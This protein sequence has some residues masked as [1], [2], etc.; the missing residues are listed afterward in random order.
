[1]RR[2]VLPLVVSLASSLWLGSSPAL[3]ENRIALVIGN[4]AYQS[5]TALPNPANDAKAMAELLTAAGFEVIAA[6]DLT[7]NDM[8]QTVRDFAEKVAAKG[9]DTI[10]L[11]FYAGHGLQVDG[12]NFLV[13]VDAHVEREADVPI[14]AF[15][16]GDL[17][18]ALAA[19][20]SKARIVMLD[21]CRNNP[22]A[23]IRKTTGRGLAIVDA[24]A[25]S[26]ISYSTSPG[27]EAEDGAGADSPYTTALLAV[28]RQPGL[29]IEQAFKR[30]RVAVNRATDGRQIPWESSSLGS[31]FF[32]FPGPGNVVASQPVSQTTATNTPPPGGSGGLGPT[33]YARPPAKSLEAW[34][35]ELLSV[36]PREA[37][38]IVIREDTIEGY[39]A[40]LAVYPL[41]PFAPRVRS[42]FD[43]RRE[44]IAWYF[45]VTINTVE[46]YRAFLAM[47]PN[48]D[49]TTTARRLVERARPRSMT[50][51]LN[52]LHLPSAA[53]ASAPVG[54][55][56]APSPVAAATPV[57]VA[58][59]CPCRDPL[60]PQRTFT[61][62]DP[63]F[64]P[65]PERIRVPPDVRLPPNDGGFIRPPPFVRPLPRPNDGVI[66]VPPSHGPTLPPK[67][68][69]P[70]ASL[71]PRGT[72]QPPPN[73]NTLPPKVTVIPPRVI[74][75]P[76]PV[77]FHPPPQNNGPG[78]GSVVFRPVPFRGGFNNAPSGGPVIR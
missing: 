33:G 62:P 18:N 26:I 19:V 35:R 45:A 56:P 9:Q 11:V 73:V 14:Q 61:P 2:P 41:P 42:L 13:P 24:P 36:A 21:A 40:Y 3:A 65:P 7:Q 27:A 12:E 43:R 58:P 66:V 22:F 53:Q 50:A 69:G 68:S 51:S 77:V 30:V 55:P 52:P 67:D 59:T 78:K 38:E 64:P 46:S 31:D 16:L 47:Y 1:M 17:M 39:E 15:R 28:A 6:P 63:T 57:N 49:L 70:G 20:P 37:Y 4:A 71:P 54:Q 76:P 5:V 25:G 34:R 72:P 75:P 48:S 32:F 44:M 60:P 8:R 10:S 74:Q 29:P 23:E